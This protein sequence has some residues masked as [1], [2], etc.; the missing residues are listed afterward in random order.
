[1]RLW[2]AALALAGCSEDFTF[3][4]TFVFGSAIAGFQAEM[5]CPTVAGAQC[6]DRNSDWYTWITRP[7]LLADSSTH[8]EG[9]PPSAGP[10]FFELYAQDLDRAANELHHNGFRLSIEWSRLFPTATDGI[11]GHDALKAAASQ[12]ALAYYHALFDGLKQ[13]G[14]QPF[15]TL[16]H[17]SLPSWIHDAYACHT[18]IATCTN[19][20]WLDQTRVETE[21]AKYAGFCAAEFGDRVDR[22]AS[23]NEPFTAVVLAGFLAPTD[24]RTNPPGV[25]LKIPEAKTAYKSMIEA[26][27]KV[28]DAVK[29]N[30]TV[31]A[32]GDGVPAKI[33]IV[34]NLQ[35]VAANDPKSDTDVRGMQHLQYLEDQ[36]FLDGVAK[37][38]FDQN[39]DG[40]AVQRDDL[41]HRMDFI[42]INYYAKTIAE[43][44]DSSVYPQISPL[45]DFDFISL[46]YDYDY[47]QGIKEVLQFAQRYGVPLVISETG[48][49]Q[50]DDADGPSRWAVRTLA[51]VKRAMNAGVNVEGYFYWTLTDNYEWNHGMSIHMGIYGVDKSDPSKTRQHRNLVDVYARIAQE[52]KI[53]D[54]L[55]AK[56][57]P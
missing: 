46:G 25:S 15:V 28:Y 41:A 11:E 6:E 40:N 39:W 20:G 33:G 47:P 29:M 1:M 16:N 55:L 38:S 9:D 4:K 10:G 14:L 43:G 50:S 56:F 5:G 53:P 49:A 19:R 35:A 27:A 30:D 44:T 51:W 42:G 34:Y 31:D 18:N 26:H 21:M 12:P 7:E 3:P 13:R 8:L 36:M 24:Q 2:L 57:P 17:Y 54:D 48:A 22:W 32:D 52:H 37:G 45:L 23:L